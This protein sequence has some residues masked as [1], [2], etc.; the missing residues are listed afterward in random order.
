MGK[1]YEALE[2]VEKEL[3]KPGNRA[4]LN[5]DERRLLAPPKKSRAQIAS[6]RVV[7]LKTKLITRYATDNIK[8]ILITGI[9][10]GIGASTTAISLAT[11]LAKDSRRKVLLVDAN[12]RT[13]GLHDVFKTKFKDGVY[14]LLNKKTVP[15]L[16]LRRIGPGELFLLPSGVNRDVE[17]GYFESPRFDK[18]LQSA[19]KSF[20]YVILDSAPVGS[21]RDCQA[22]CA[23]VDGVVLVLESGK[24]RSQVALRAKKELEDAGGR[25][26][27]LIL[28]RQKHY[29]PEWIYKRL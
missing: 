19:R 11:A 15:S 26:L 16:K 10:P 8:T 12:L 13:P 27:G 23:R 29:I 4:G 24:T 5:T 28:N 1:A 2:R 25:I 20:D 14:D 21:F 17:N 18:F 6:R 9:A 22:I 3:R 7:D